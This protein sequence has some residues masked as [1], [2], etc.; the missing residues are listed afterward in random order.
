MFIVHSQP[1]AVTMLSFSLIWPVEVAEW[2]IIPVFY[3]YLW[4]YGVGRGVPGVPSGQNI[5]G[6]HAEMHADDSWMISALAREWLPSCIRGVGSIGIYGLKG[7]YLRNRRQE[8]SHIWWR[9]SLGGLLQM[10]ETAKNSAEKTIYTLKKWHPRMCWRHDVIRESAHCGVI[11]WFVENHEP[12]WILN[13]TKEALD[14]PG[15][16]AQ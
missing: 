6:N 13:N 9:G 1:Q 12:S 11:R 10:V 8:C 15:I 7:P 2:H 14:W 5:M 16:M 3:R 4:R